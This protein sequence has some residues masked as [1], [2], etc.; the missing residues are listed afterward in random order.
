MGF[1]HRIPRNLRAFVIIGFVLI[2]DLLFAI[3]TFVAYR[4]EGNSQYGSMAIYNV[5]T[6]D[7]DPSTPLPNQKNQITI[8]MKV[9]KVDFNTN[10]MK[11]TIRFAPTGTFQSQKSGI[12]AG[13]LIIPATAASTADTRTLATV[14]FNFGE[15]GIKKFSNNSIM[16]KV[17]LTVPLF[18]GDVSDFPFDRFESLSIVS[19]TYSFDKNALVPIAMVVDGSM[20][21]FVVS[22]N[23]FGPSTS[24]DPDDRTVVFGTQIIRAGTTK[25]FAILMLILMFFLPL[26]ALGIAIDV[27]MRKRQFG[28]LSVFTSLL[29]ALPALRKNIPDSPQIGSSMDILIFFW[30]MVIAGFSA[31][32]MLAQYVFRFEDDKMKQRR[33]ENEKLGQ[34]P[35][36]QMVSYASSNNANNNFVT[37]FYPV[38]S[39]KL[40]SSSKI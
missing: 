14:D 30:S 39:I 29:F 1:L 18:N 31:L 20:N 21:G 40:R 10:E 13:T 35:A 8:M 36:V 16:S 4:R 17:E 11:I 26:M 9:S 37:G 25:L 28:S 33:L 24:T 22:P 23:I 5:T 38:G 2:C 19:A 6:P 34:P 12:A 27:L 32:I 15:L 7:L 3:P